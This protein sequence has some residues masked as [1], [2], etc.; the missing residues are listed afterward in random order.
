MKFNLLTILN[1]FADRDKGQCIQKMLF[2]QKVFF[3]VVGGVGVHRENY[4]E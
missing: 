2:Y 1:K 4:Q 3:N